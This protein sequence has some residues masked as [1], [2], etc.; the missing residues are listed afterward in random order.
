MAREKR[1][2]EKLSVKYNGLHALAT[3]ERAN[4]IV[5]LETK[6]MT[7]S[8][9]CNTGRTYLSLR[10]TTRE[11]SSLAIHVVQKITIIRAQKIG[12]FAV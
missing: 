10:V 1:N 5:Q 6:A 2:E 12:K 8:S 9:H 4:I 11:N 7:T 3:L